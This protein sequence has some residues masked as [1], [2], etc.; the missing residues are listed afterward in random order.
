MHKST[1]PVKNRLFFITQGSFV[2]D[3]PLTNA[4][5]ISVVIPLLNEAGNVLPLVEEIASALEAYA[6]TQD[7]FEIICVDDGSTDPT[8]QEVL[9]AKSAHPNVRLV[10]HGQ[11]LGMSAALRNGIRRARSP[12]ILTLDGD[13]QNDPADAPRL[14]DLA[15][16]K[17]RERKVLVAGI[18]VNRQDTWGK[19]IASKVANKIRKTL[20]NDHCPDTGC[21]LKVFQ[22]DA[23]LELPFFN[24]LHRFMPA[25]LH[26]YGHET[27]FTPVNDRL[28]THGVSKS[29]FV[30]RAVKGFFDLCGVLWIMYRTPRPDRGTEG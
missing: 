10:R 25:L 22:R 5:L 3:A 4:P 30:G 12:W 20:L 9:R 14:L 11:R 17:G 15:W 7:R 24:G 27:L 18:R 2:L 21:S 16:A 1:N 13:R 23:Y 6:P 19:K 29:D 8:A 26:L 28:R